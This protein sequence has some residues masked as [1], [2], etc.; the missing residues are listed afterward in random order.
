MRDLEGDLSIAARRGV[1]AHR[2]VVQGKVS[3][4]ESVSRAWKTAARRAPARALETAA[5]PR[6]PRQARS[7]MPLNYG[8]LTTSC[9]EVLHGWSS[10]AACD[11]LSLVVE[12]TKQGFGSVVAA[13][14]KAFQVER[15]SISFYLYLLGEWTRQA[16]PG[17]LPNGPPGPGGTS[18]PEWLLALGTEALAA[19]VVDV[20]IEDYVAGTLG[21]TTSRAACRELGGQQEAGRP[22]GCSYER[23]LQEDADIATAD[24][25]APPIVDDGM[26]KSPSYS[27]L[28]RPARTPSPPHSSP[29]YASTA[30]DTTSFANSSASASA[31]AGDEFTSTSQTLSALRRP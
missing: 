8:L 20:L 14:E 27:K 25:E 29:R 5:H 9:R 10:F 13:F 16:M 22:R 15:S 26:S 1:P 6:G 23:Q 18:N 19:K 7:E 28:T 21:T 2:A 11:Y 4:G 3:H 30:T 31:M 17:S 12:P 24:A